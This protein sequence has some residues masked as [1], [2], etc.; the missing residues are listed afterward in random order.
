MKLK[1]VYSFVNNKGGVGKTTSV[2]N[3]A[4]GIIQRDPK[5]KV[6]C[7]DLDA[8]CNLSDQMGW[9]Q[10]KLEYT[11]QEINNNLA[12]ALGL[13]LQGSLSVYKKKE[14]LYYVPACPQ[15]ESI[16]PVLN[17]LMKPRQMLGL[18]FGNPVKDMTG[19]G[20]TLIQDSF[21]YVLID[22][23][24]SLSVLTIN[25]LDASDYVVTPI[26]YDPLSIKGLARIMNAVKE[27]NAYLNPD[28]RIKGILPV[29]CN[30][31][32]TL[33]KNLIGI[34]EEKYGDLLMKSRVRDCIRVKESQAFNMDIFEYA[35]DCTAA[36]DYMKVVEELIEE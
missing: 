17:S 24:P 3:V 36:Q 12:T 13:G 19:D 28:L 21:D 16:E 8:Q 29:K 18:L 34:L 2:L 11:E 7:I 22:C 4:A 27:V 32:T 20:L 33:A 5:A 26:F 23:A 15:L 14:G 10:K 31:R 6:L 30:D 35:P 9:E 1:K 25:A